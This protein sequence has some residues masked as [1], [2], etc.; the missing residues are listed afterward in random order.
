MLGRQS[1]AL[2]LIALIGL[3]LVAYGGYRW[4]TAE[5][6][7]DAGGQE[8]AVELAYQADVAKM[9]EQMDGDWSPS[10]EWERNRRAAIREEVAAENE[11]QSEHGRSWMIAGLAALIF[12]FGR[13][14][15]APL[16]RRDE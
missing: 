5:P 10:D 3:G 9:R 14:F 8:L 15:A 12:S 11:R 13:M 7:L 16:F 1:V 6:A 4:Y 2:W